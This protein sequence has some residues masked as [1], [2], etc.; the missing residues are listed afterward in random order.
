VKCGSD[1]QLLM[2]EILPL[3]P[4][5]VF[6]HFHDVFYPFEYPAYVIERGNYWN[7][8]YFLRAFLSYNY[9]WNIYF[10]NDYVASSFNDFIKEKMPLCIRN[11]G[12][13][14]YMQRKGKG[15]RAGSA[16]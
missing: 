15:Q 5:G 13:S 7:E 11:S 8:N 10:F 14:L 3:L 16:S 12:G 2:F 9:E 4:P 6:V 1:V